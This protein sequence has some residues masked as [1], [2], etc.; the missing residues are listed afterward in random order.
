[1]LVAVIIIGLL[2]ATIMLSLSSARDK[3]E[4]T[5]IVSNMRT[6]KS[7]LLL[8]Y[9]NNDKWP[10]LG[11]GEKKGINTPAST[12]LT[13]YIDRTIGNEYTIIMNRSTDSNYKAYYGSV[14]VKYVGASKL[15]EGVRNQLAKMAESCDLWNTSAWN[16]QTVSYK[17]KNYDYG[18][19]YFSTGNSAIG[20]DSIH[21]P[22][23]L[24]H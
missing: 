17:G 13:G 10:D 14:F 9:T 21:L 20:M 6:I 1:M 19:Y 12:V 3:A 18:H 5:K 11:S 22:V 23:Y 15:S 8:Y 16:S 2:A 7:A 4:A 24:T